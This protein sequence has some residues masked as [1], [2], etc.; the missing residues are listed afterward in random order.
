MLDTYYILIGGATAKTYD[1]YIEKSLCQFTIGPLALSLTR[2]LEEI[3]NESNHS[4]QFTTSAICLNY[5]GLKES[6]SWR[7]I[8]IILKVN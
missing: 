1:N 8:V 7:N 2:V 6:A 4:D 3:K 5:R